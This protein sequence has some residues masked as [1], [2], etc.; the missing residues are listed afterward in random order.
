MFPSPTLD[1]SVPQPLYYSL[2]LIFFWLLSYR[3]R[4]LHRETHVRNA[5]S[6]G[7]QVGR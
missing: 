1:N 3:Q 4:L 7:Y 2:A 6:L 5:C